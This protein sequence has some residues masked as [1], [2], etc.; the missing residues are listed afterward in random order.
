MRILLQL[1]F[2]FK[3]LRTHCLVFYL[4]KRDRQWYAL[5]YADALSAPVYA[6]RVIDCT[7]VTC[8]RVPRLDPDD[9]IL[10]SELRKRGLTVSSAIWSDPEVDWPLSRLCLVRSTW[11]YHMRYNEFQRWIDHV[12][13]V[14]IVKNDPALLTWSSHKS[15]LREIGARGVP[16]VPFA[17]L[18]RGQTANLAAIRADRGWKDTVIKPAR[19]AATHG[20]MHVR[21][22]RDSLR[23]GQGH[24]DHLLVENDV[25]VQPYFESVRGYGERALIFIS[26]AYSHAVSKKAFDTVLAIR[27]APLA[28]IEASNYELEIASNALGSCPGEPLY[29]RVDLLHDGG[30]PYVN[31]VELIEP[32]LYFGADATA[33]ARFADALERQLGLE[34]SEART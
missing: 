29:A 31:E 19:G 10:V 5:T 25:L 34:T 15:Y 12:A 8:E 26:G 17:W 28:R 21:S 14:S 16:V 24:L 4:S 23:M 22:N 3:I 27:D 11:D 9:W 33:A 18:E 32:A 30:S 20:V 1:N 7:L 6:C 13:S 2:L